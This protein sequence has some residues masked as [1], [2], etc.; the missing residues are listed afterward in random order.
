MEL[1][2]ELGDDAEV[3]A[4]AA[5]GPEQVRVLGRAGSTDLAV[6]GDDLDRAQV[7][8]GHAVA[9]HQP[10]E[11]AAERQTGDAGRGDRAAGRRQPVRAGRLVEVGPGRAALGAGSPRLPDRR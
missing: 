5:N 1:V 11:T 7:V 3:A 6:G 4:A 9:A 10:A 2:L 8:A